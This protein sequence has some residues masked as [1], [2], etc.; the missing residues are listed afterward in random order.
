MF[1]SESSRLQVMKRKSPS[2]ELL[3]TQTVEAGSPVMDSIPEAGGEV[4]GGGVGS[5]KVNE[6]VANMNG[7]V[8]K[9]RGLKRYISK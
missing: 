9:T 8:G 4:A 3:T 7:E 1:L 2:P 6:E 5:P